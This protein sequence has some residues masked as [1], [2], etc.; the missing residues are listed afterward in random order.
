MNTKPQP[1]WTL[2]VPDARRPVV[3][4]RH[5]ARAVGR[6][7]AAVDL[8]GVPLERPQHHARIRVQL[9]RCLISLSSSASLRRACSLLAHRKFWKAAAVGAYAWMM[10]HVSCGSSGSSRAS[11]CQSIVAKRYSCTGVP[12][13]SM[14]RHLRS[15]R[16]RRRIFSPP[17]DLTGL[18]LAAN[19]I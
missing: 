14:C 16:H 13:G 3:R 4:R 5:D 1:P 18:K 2:R 12:Q 10:N 7:G 19:I 15:C 6:E 9:S 8:A 11:L 17:P